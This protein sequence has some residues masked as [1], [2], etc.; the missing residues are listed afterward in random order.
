MRA[1]LGIALFATDQRAIDLFGGQLR[2]RQPGI[3]RQLLGWGSGRL[4]RGARGRRQ[5]E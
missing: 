4:V 3:R 5:T 1:G 2:K